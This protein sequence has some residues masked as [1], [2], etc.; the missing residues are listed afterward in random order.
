[1]ILLLGGT[2]ETAAIAAELAKNGHSVLVSTATDTSLDVGRHELIARRIGRLDVKSICSIVEADDICVIVDATHPFATAAS[3]TVKEASGI[4]GIPF[5]T[6]LRPHV[7]YDYENIDYAKDHAD[8]AVKAFADGKPVLL[9]SG[10]RNLLQYVELS[11]KKN[12]K[13]FARVLPHPESEAACRAAG[14]PEKNVIFQ[15]GPFSVEQTVDLIK[16][17]GIG[18]VVTKDSGKEG[19]V[20]EK[21]EAARVTGCRIV[22]VQRPKTVTENSFESA[23]TLAAGVNDLLGRVR[24]NG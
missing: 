16:K 19:G 14:L 9:T 1:M 22:M 13:L 7:Q 10:S 24:E 20:F 23:K 12:V 4:A 21:V 6:F 15:R 3:D 2:G 18:T 17:F 11:K 8:A 5:V